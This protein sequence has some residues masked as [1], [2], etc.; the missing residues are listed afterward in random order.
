AFGAVD[1]SG[2]QTTC[3]AGNSSVPS[4][5]QTG[6]AQTSPGCPGRP[7]I[8]FG[9][10]GTRI[11][12]MMLKTITAPRIRNQRDDSP[13]PELRVLGGWAG[14]SATS[15]VTSCSL[16]TLAPHTGARL[17]AALGSSLTGLVKPA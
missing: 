6:N 17:D 3:G 15:G 9:N 11:S 7:S 13:R 12:A 5:K 16:D 2:A 14:A 4:M 1:P 10:G 8:S